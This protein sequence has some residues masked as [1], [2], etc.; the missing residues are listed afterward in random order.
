MTA[1]D[2]D[3]VETAFSRLMR[4]LWPLV[5]Q[6]W[7]ETELTMAQLKALC[8]LH[9]RGRASAAGF[10]LTSPALAGVPPPGLRRSGC[11]CLSGSRRASPGGL[12]VAAAG[13]PARLKRSSV[14]I[15]LGPVRSSGRQHNAGTNIEQ[16]HDR[17]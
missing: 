12:P 13:G 16:Q 14:P 17:E 5:A 15:I 10:S 9:A 3:V 8:V 6:T 1:D 7:V 2:S 4:A 11:A